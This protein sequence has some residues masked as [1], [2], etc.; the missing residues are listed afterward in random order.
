[1]DEGG[2]YISVVKQFFSS[3]FS[4]RI[5]LARLLILA[6]MAINI[7]FL[8]ISLPTKYQRLYNLEPTSTS[9]PAFSGWTPQ[10]IQTVRIELGLSKQVVAVA[11][12]TASLVCLACFWSM[13]GL[14]FW[15]KSG[16]WFGLAVA[17]I[18]F[19]TGPGFSGLFFA[20][21]S[22]APNWLNALNSFL[23]AIIWPTFFVFLYLFPNGNFVPR[24]TRYLAVLPY[25]IFLLVGIFPNSTAV[26]SINTVLLLAYA[27]GGLV[28][29]VSR[30]YRVSNP[31]ERQQT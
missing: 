12:F 1:L 6:W 9:G 13:C 14:L 8:T 10:Q 24:F 23:A 11:M 18:L 3:A 25:L 2:V 19:M 15:R 29:Q 27:F 21:Q 5:D 17:L 31:E 22:Q 20:N 4:R 30:Y 7:V 16:T 26:D 28:S